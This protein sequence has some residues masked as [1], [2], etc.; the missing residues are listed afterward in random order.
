MDIS[1]KV[2]HELE[3]S[4]S[5]DPMNEKIQMIMDNVS[6]KDALVNNNELNKHEFK[7]TNEISKANYSTDQHYSGRCWMFAALNV[8]RHKLIKAYKLD[9]TF[10]LSQSYLFKFHKLESCNNALELGYHLLKSRSPKYIKSLHFNSL[11]ANIIGDGGCWN[12]F[13]NLVNKYGIVPKSCYP[14]Y[15][16]HKNTHY[17]NIILMS[18]IK[19]AMLEF[20]KNIDILDRIEFEIEK[21][22]ILLECHKVIFKCFGKDPEQFSW[23]GKT[24]E[25]PKTFYKQIVLPII[26]INDLVCISNVPN[27]KYNTKLVCKHNPATIPPNITEYE[28]MDEYMPSYI[29]LK[30]NRFKK[31]IKKTIHEK[32]T[33]VFFGANWDSMFKFESVLDDSSLALDLLLGTL[34]KNISKKD[35][36]DSFELCQNHAMV[37]S[38]YNEVDCKIDRWKV[39]NSHGS[40]KSKTNGILIMTDSWFDKN[41][42]SAV[43]HKDCL[44]KNMRIKATKYL[45]HWYPLGALMM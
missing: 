21:Q 3:K 8:I 30:L 39:E 19:K 23:K 34:Y 14:D 18:I 33:C 35:L 6:I 16:N 11:Y 4:L 5:S 13:V 41:V 27:I 2:I 17:V 22:K 20:S 28:N 12:M 31:C 44:P 10:E 7:F 37:I 29:N 25:D 1:S 42:L 9:K 32:N 15:S 43:V 24:Y 40:K 45:E 38:G 36:L 26:N